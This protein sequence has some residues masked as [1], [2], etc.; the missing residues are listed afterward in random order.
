MN[1]TTFNF[2]TTFKFERCAPPGAGMG[3]GFGDLAADRANRILF[4]KS[5]CG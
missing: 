1:V 3:W 4:A 2:K 5:A